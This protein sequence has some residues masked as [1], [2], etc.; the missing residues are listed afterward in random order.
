MSAASLSNP[1]PSSLESGPSLA[2][3]LGVGLILCALL[4]LVWKTSLDGQFQFD[5]YGNIVENRAIRRIW[6]L[7]SFLESN[8]PLGLYSFALNYQ[9]SKLEPQGYHLV[10]LVIHVIN[11]LLLFSG[12][13]LTEQIRCGAAARL[14]VPFC[15][16]LLWGVHSLNTQAVTNIVQ[17]YESMAALGYLASWVGVILVARGVR[18]A[19]AMVLLAAWFG[20]L[21]KE[22]YATAPVVIALFDRCCLATSWKEVFQKRWATYLLMATPLLWF[23]PSVARWFDPHRN[24]SMGFGLKTISSWQYLRTQPEVILHYLR[25]SFWPDPLCFDYVWKI[26]NRPV[27]YLP[28]GGVLLTALG[29]GMYWQ[30]RR[31]LA[32]TMILAFFLILAPTSS[33]M[34]IADLAVEHRMYLPLVLVVVGVVYSVRTILERISGTVGPP[35]W[36]MLMAL[37]A[38]GL[39]WRTQVRNADYQD[40]IRLWNSVLAVRPDNPRAHFMLGSEY[41]GRG[42]WKDAYAAFQRAVALPNAVADFHVGMGDCEREFG[43]L[44]KAISSYQAAIKRKPRHMKANNGLGVIYHR[45]LD[46][47]KARD[48]FRIATEEGLPEARYNLASVLID[49]GQERNAIPYLE[50]AIED[51]PQFDRAARRLAWILSTS[52]DGTLRDG[53]RALELLQKHCQVKLSTSAYTW[54]TQAAA[55]AETGDFAAAEQAATQAIALAQQIQQTTFVEQIEVRLAQYRQRQAWRGRQDGPQSRIAPQAPGAGS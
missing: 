48:A 10:N 53:K 11:A 29:L 17:R 5:D 1:E 32:G 14:S 52:P 40:G 44:E 50:Q 42:Q 13:W 4:L 21:S 20:M 33:V 7:D 3:R 15:G 43:E 47:P 28:L 2:F 16:A 34:P 31:Q 49:M 51:H 12:L 9:T 24:T 38:L 8:R 19:N 54:D 23:L 37:A 22:I 55:L 35:A 26:Q 27:V 18:A 6:P 39:A 41:Q 25:L 45:Q 30:T 36:G 46:L